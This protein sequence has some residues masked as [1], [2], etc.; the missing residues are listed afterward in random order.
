MIELNFP[1][2]ELSGYPLEQ[3]GLTRFQVSEL[4]SVGLLSFNP[5]DRAEFAGYDIEELK[6]LKKIYF[7]SG[8]ARPHVLGMLAKLQKPYR[9]SFDKIYWDFGK[10]DWKEVKLS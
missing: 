10:Q 9:Y 3:S 5:S 7:D 2:F 6:F 4:H 1:V 8:L